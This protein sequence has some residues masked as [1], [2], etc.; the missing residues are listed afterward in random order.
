M[1][2]MRGEWHIYQCGV[3]VSFH[4]GRYPPGV[5][6]WIQQEVLD[7]LVM[8]RWAQM[9]PAQRKAA[10]KAALA[11]HGGNLGTVAL[12]AHVEHTSLADA[13]EACQREAEGAGS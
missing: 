8:M 6:L 3:G 4:A 10:S 5:N 12:R 2:Y 9:S 7:Q 1:A 13:E 11:Q